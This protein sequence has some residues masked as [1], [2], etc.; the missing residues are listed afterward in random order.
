MFST[1]DPTK[2]IFFPAR[3]C[4]SPNRDARPPG[5]S[6]DLI[7]VHGISLPP[8]AFGTEWVEALFMNRIPADHPDPEL[9]SVSGLRVSAH[10]FIDR[11]GRIVQYVPFGERAWHAG[12]S[13]WKGRKRCNDFSVGIELEGTDD[14]AYECDQYRSLAA[15]ILALRCAYPSLI[16]G[17]VVGHSEIAP[18]RKTDPGPAFDWA[19]LHRILGDGTCSIEPSIPG[20]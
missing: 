16:A 18:G 15:S 7:V 1:I 3:Q 2:G 19:R 11:C 6:L 20:S 8:G 4:W 13:F 10:L 9:R 5:I 14:Q 12:T 17:A